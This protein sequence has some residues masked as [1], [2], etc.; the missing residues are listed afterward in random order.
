MKKQYIIKEFL[1]GKF[2][3]SFGEECFNPS[4]SENSFEVLFFNSRKDAEE[5]LMELDEKFNGIRFQ[6][7]ELYL[8]EDVSEFSLALGL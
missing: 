4:F 6:I 7:V 3:T 8:K 5:L 1:S 2:L